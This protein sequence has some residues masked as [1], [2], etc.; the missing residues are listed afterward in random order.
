M[1]TLDKFVHWFTEH[2]KHVLA[3]HIEKDRTALGKSLKELEAE[4]DRARM[5]HSRL[6]GLLE[7]ARQLEQAVGSPA[8]GGH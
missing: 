6:E 1:H 3:S 5:Y 2:D 4:R 7:S 8:E